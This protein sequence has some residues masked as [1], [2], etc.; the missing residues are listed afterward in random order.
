LLP[1]SPPPPSAHPHSSQT[2]F[3]TGNTR[4]ASS[5]EFPHRLT[6]LQFLHKSNKFLSH[7]PCGGCLSGL[8]FVF[9]LCSLTYYT[10]FTFVR[11]RSLVP[12]VVFVPHPRQ[13]KF[14]GNNKTLEWRTMFLFG[15]FSIF[16][17]HGVDFFNFSYF[18]SGSPPLRL[19]NDPAFMVATSEFWF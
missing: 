2:F 10:N 18:F 1:A 4:H 6:T 12:H 5:P 17:C 8:S 19:P 15:V 9:F 14:S 11:L 3:E 16:A 7:T 13:P